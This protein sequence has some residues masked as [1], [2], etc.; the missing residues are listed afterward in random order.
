MWFLQECT[1]GFYSASCPPEL[2][3]FLKSSSPAQAFSSLY[4]WW[5]PFCPRCRA[6]HLSLLNIMLN[7]LN[8]NIRVGGKQQASQDISC[9]CWMTV[10]GSHN[11][12]MSLTT[13]ICSFFSCGTGVGSLDRCGSPRCL[14]CQN[15]L[16]LSSCQ[17]TIVFPHLQVEK[18]SSGGQNL[19]SFSCHHLG[20]LLAFTVAFGRPYSHGGGAWIPSLAVPLRVSAK[21]FWFPIYYSYPM[22]CAHH[23]PQLVTQWFSHIYHWWGCHRHQLQ[24]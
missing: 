12:R 10:P 24:P 8:R 3:L 6:L 23:I 7:R 17:R 9:H 1:V 22:Q 13:I 5:E 15:F 19:P 14:L 4:W 18:E 11:R 20:N 2:S 16:F 21:I